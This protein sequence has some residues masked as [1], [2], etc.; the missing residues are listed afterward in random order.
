MNI[1]QDIKQ[2]LS[3]AAFLFCEVIHATEESK[4]TD[5]ASKRGK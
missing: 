2:S 4:R 1:Y 5:K 3:V